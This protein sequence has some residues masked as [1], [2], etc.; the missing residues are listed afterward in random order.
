M[1]KRVIPLAFLGGLAVLIVMGIP[2][3]KRYL[4][5]RNM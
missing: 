4:R 5:L 3:L 1:L 2:D